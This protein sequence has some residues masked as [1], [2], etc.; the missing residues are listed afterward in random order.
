M[1][2]NC[3]KCEIDECIKST[4]GIRTLKIELKILDHPVY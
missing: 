1:I 4:I 2:F 3:L